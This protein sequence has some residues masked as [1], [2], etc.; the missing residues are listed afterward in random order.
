MRKSFTLYKTASLLRLASN[1]TITTKYVKY[2]RIGLQ[3]NMLLAIKFN[4]KTAISRGK[5]K[6]LIELLTSKNISIKKYLGK[7]HKNM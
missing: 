3:S 7:A 5:F 6:H 1:L 4:S 2:T